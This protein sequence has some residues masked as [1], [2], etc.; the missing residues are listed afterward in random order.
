MSVK[1]LRAIAPPK[2]LPPSPWVLAKEII[3][4]ERDP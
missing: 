3:S 1:M 2:T 4:G